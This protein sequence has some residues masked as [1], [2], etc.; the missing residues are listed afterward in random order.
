M[1]KRK[2]PK[3]CKPKKNQTQDKRPRSFFGWAI[4]S[5][6]LFWH[7]AFA[8][9]NFVSSGVIRQHNNGYAAKR[10]S[11]LQTDAASFLTEKGIDVPL[12]F[13]LSPAETMV[14]R[15]MKYGSWAVCPHCGLH[16][17][18]KLNQR[19]LDRPSLMP[20]EIPCK[21]CH[22][23][24]LVPKYEDIPECLRALT[25]AQLQLLRP[26]DLHQGPVCFPKKVEGYRMK[27][28]ATKL[29]WKPVSVANAISAAGDSEV[30]KVLVFFQA[31]HT[32]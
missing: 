30:S 10:K 29:R 6:I 17:P 18:I 19:H 12:R 24:Y 11:T 25:E 3:E 4:D 26:I 9:L 1:P 14:I 16:K 13:W 28:E 20:T 21:K 27:T 15:W 8:M 7:R 31:I 23:P 32:C 5:L 2:R 22:K